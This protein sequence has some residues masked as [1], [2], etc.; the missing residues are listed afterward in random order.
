MQNR[1]IY[2]Y[3]S[4]WGALF[5]WAIS[6]TV[7]SQAEAQFRGELVLEAGDDPPAQKSRPKRKPNK[8]PQKANKPSHPSLTVVTLA[9]RKTDKI[10]QT[11]LLKNGDKLYSREI[12]QFRIR[13]SHPGYL[14]IV[15]K[16]SS[17]KLYTL[18]PAG[19]SVHKIS[20][21]VWN[22]IPDNQKWYQLDDNPG[23]ETFYF[24]VDTYQRKDIKQLRHI[25]NR[26]KYQKAH[27]MLNKMVG[28][29][30]I[31]G[32]QDGP[33]VSMRFDQG[34]KIHLGQIQVAQPTNQKAK[35]IVYIMKIRHLSQL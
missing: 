1:C 3:L 2:R 10:E 5:L 23:I 15:L 24:I 7:F 13:S 9:H 11:F 20:P 14:Y 26:K 18:Y 22:T 32:T 12:F 16:D 21:D 34:G 30:G 28:F 31:A 29:R 35:S 33:N 6:L 8:R 27:Q 25:I 17:K 19:N 4:V